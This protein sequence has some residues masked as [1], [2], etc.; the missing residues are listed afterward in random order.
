MSRVLISALVVSVFGIGTAQAGSLNINPFPMGSAGSLSAQRSAADELER[1]SRGS[2]EIS[3]ELRQQ[4]AR[5]RNRIDMTPM[6]SEFSSLGAQDVFEPKIVKIEPY[7]RQR[8]NLDDVRIEILPYDASD[9]PRAP[10]FLT[11]LKGESVEDVLRGWSHSEGV[12]LLWK[13]RLRFG[14]VDALSVEEGY[15]KSVETLLSQFSDTSRP[16]VGQLDTDP[17]TGVRTLSV[18]T[19]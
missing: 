4:E 1:S 15:E 13:T 11:A 19:R 3:V 2:D 16:L 17:V 9:N 5:G 7:R 8:L 14:V 10:A 12:G 18:M 6:P